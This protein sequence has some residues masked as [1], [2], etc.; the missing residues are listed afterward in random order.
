M[1]AGELVIT[2]VDGPVAE[3]RLNRPQALN[4]LDLPLARAL[5]AAVDEISGRADVR[6]VLITAEGRG[7]VAGG[8]VSAMAA[9]PQRGHEVVDDLLAVLNPAILALRN[10]PPVIAAVRGV[11]A[12]AGLSLLAG[13]DLVV[14]D[15]AAKL[16]FAYDQVAGVADC[17]GSWFLTHKIGRGRIMEM[18]LLGRPMTPQTALALGLVT[19]LA[20]EAEVEARAREMAARVARGPTASFNHVRALV[21]AAA[22][23]T[24]VDQLAAE[25]A[26]F[27][28]AAQSDDFREGVAAFTARR[29]PEFKGY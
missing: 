14:L 18:L 9:D 13:A 15:E 11:A 28:A 27:V 10:G 20:P 4:A 21:D 24:L 25:R 8:D 5:A 26:A 17:G 23:A 16:V 3:L 19:E 29:K 22:H 7:F 2:T 12:G 6:A 1:S